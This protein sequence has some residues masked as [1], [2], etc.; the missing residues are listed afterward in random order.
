M[1]DCILCFAATYLVEQMTDPSNDA[2][3][4]MLE[5]VRSDARGSKQVGSQEIASVLQSAEPAGPRCSAW[6]CQND[7]VQRGFLRQSWT[8][9]LKLAVTPSRGVYKPIDA[10]HAA[11][12]SLP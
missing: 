10:A 12:H 6:S 11:G 1:V 7:A 3:R 4:V 2:G 8:Q 5:R 9:N